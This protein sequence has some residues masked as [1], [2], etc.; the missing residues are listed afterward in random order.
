MVSFRTTDALFKNFATIAEPLSRLTKKN[1]PFHWTSEDD[2]A[3]N[4]L[5]QALLNSITLSFP[6]PGVPC[7]LDTDASDVAIGSVLS[8]VING[9][10]RPIAFYS[11][12]MNTAQ[13]NYCPTRRELLAVIASL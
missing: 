9:V 6:I 12:V 1:T 7:I 11:R 8:Q 10:E 3:F 2:T 4:K 5:K 13:R